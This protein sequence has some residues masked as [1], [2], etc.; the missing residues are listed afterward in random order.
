MPHRLAPLRRLAACLFLPIALLAAG[1]TAAAQERQPVLDR[2]TRLPAAVPVQDWL[3]AG[4]PTEMPV[5]PANGST[6][7]QSPPGFTW[8]DVAPAAG[9]RFRLS[10]P[11]GLTVEQQID[12]LVEQATDENILARTWKGWRPWL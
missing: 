1:G 11:D 6:V 3:T 9:Y 5:R 2:I 7:L 12:A 4:D 10:G 8:P